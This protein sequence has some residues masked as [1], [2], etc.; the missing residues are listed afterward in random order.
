MK[1][2]E[3]RVGRLESENAATEDFGLYVVDEDI[4]D[5]RM[6]YQGRPVIIRPASYVLI[7]HKQA[8]PRSGA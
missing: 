8:R 2:L 4:P 7:I 5:G 3:R 1:D 6:C